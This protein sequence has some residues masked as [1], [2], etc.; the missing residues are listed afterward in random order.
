MLLWSQRVQLDPSARHEGIEGER[1]SS[2]MPSIQAMRMRISGL[3]TYEIVV[4]ELVTAATANVVMP[5]MRFDQC[6]WNGHVT[7]RMKLMDVVATNSP[8]AKILLDE[9]SFI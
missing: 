3:A 1:R 6:S 2:H 7:M 8:D 5:S 4:L 9:Q